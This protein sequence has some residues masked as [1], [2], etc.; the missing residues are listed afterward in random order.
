MSSDSRQQDGSQSLFQQF[1]K[2]FSEEGLAGILIIGGVILFLLPV[3]PITQIAGVVFLI[4]GII[5]WF[6]DW[7]WG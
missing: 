6:V 4:L 2:N 5:T 1:F 3:V 7:L